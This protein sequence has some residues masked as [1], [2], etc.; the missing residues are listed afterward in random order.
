MF[1]AALPCSRRVPYQPYQPPPSAYAAR[2]QEV[3]LSEPPA[4]PPDLFLPHVDKERAR[5][6]EEKALRVGG[7]AVQC[8]LFVS[9]LAWRAAAVNARRARVA[10]T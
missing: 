6:R 3:L 10:A 7:S 8:G 9:C 1:A 4:S 5:Q 2:P